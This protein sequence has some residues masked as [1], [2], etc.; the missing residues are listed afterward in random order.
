MYSMHLYIHQPSRQI[1][2][3]YTRS[4]CHED[5]CIGSRHQ[6]QRSP[7][8][9]DTWRGVT[10]LAIHWRWAPSLDLTPANREKPPMLLCL[11]QYIGMLINFALSPFSNLYLAVALQV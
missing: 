5:T 10:C 7:L 8:Q 6:V 1:P 4:T 9:Y 11:V 3:L 2:H